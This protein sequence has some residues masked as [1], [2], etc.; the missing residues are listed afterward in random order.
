MK[1]RKGEIDGF[2]LF[3]IGVMVVLPAIKYITGYGDKSGGSSKTKVVNSNGNILDVNSNTAMSSV[4]TEI[5]I[6][7]KKVVKIVKKISPDRIDP[8]IIVIDGKYAVT[9]FDKTGK[10][11]IDM[12]DAD[13]KLVNWV[14]VTVY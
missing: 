7:I 9:S 1:K 8:E 4:N 2:W 10:W 13:E 11:T 14:K 12:Y 6:P 3:L 5:R